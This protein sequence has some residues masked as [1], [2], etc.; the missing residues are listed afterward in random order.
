M[1][2]NFPGNQI[3]SHSQN[4]LKSPEFVK[5]LIDKTDIN[6]DD[7]VVEI[8]SGKGVITSQL[9]D[10]AGQVIGIE[11]DDRLVV[12]LQKKFQQHKNVEIIKT[13]FLKWNLPQRPYKVFSNIPFNMTTD[14]IT[15][16]LGDKNSPETA[17]LI[18]QDKAAERFIGD[19]IAKDTQMSILLKP[20][21]EMKIVAKIDRRQFVPTPKINAVLA[22]FK[23][24]QK[25]L[26]EPQLTQLFRDFVVYGYNQWKPTVFEA[27]EKVFSLKQRSI[28]ERK[29]GIRE[30]KP[31]DL[32]IDQWLTLFDSFLIY[33]PDEKKYV[34]EG[35]EGRLKIQQNKLQK[36]HR[37]R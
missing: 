32:N 7:L 1:K 23:K 17:Y 16:L 11:I 10:K 31:R 22:M 19:P 27:F 37:T 15:K 3:L 18:L 21:Y 8:G 12:D 30:A 5:S 13:D 4:F 33:V 26:I 34:I 14:I 9:S 28:L 20:Y 35:A 25:P 29:I 24:K 36:W 6:I 2:S